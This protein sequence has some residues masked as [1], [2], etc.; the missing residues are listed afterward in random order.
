MQ[1]SHI[2]IWTFVQLLLAAE[3][4]HRC[5]HWSTCVSYDRLSHNCQ[6]CGCHSN[7]ILSFDMEQWLYQWTSYYN[8]FPKE[9]KIKQ[10]RILHIRWHKDKPSLRLTPTKRWLIHKSIDDVPNKHCQLIWCLINHLFTVHLLSYIPCRIETRK[11][12]EPPHGPN[13]TRAP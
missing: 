7:K 12:E 2:R 13:S 1:I 9:S 4:K 5:Q 11:M 3:D 10:V 6:F 8:W